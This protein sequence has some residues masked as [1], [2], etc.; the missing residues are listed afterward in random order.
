[1]PGLLLL[2]TNLNHAARAQDLFVATLAEWDID[3]AVAA[4]PYQIPDHPNWAG[5]EDGLVAIT[6]RNKPDS[7]PCKIVARG[8]GIVAVQR[9]KLL[10]VGCYISPNRSRPVFETYLGALGETL[11][12]HPVQQTLVLGD[13]NA[14]ST[15]WG[16]PRTDVRGTLLGEWLT[17]RGL[18]ILNSGSTNTCVRERGGSIIDLSLATR[19]VANA[20]S[21]WR[22]EAGTETLS[23]H[24]YIRIDVSVPNQTPLR[25]RADDTPRWSIRKMDEDALKAAAVA[26]TWATSDERRRV[27]DGAD[28]FRE[29]MT[30]VCD[31]GMPRVGSVPARRAVYWWTD[32]IASLRREAAKTR[33]RYTRAREK[34]GRGAVQA[35]VV[36]QLYTEYR[37]KC[38]ALQRNIA[39]AK[40]GAWKELL[41]SVEDDPWGRPYR[42][43][44]NKLRPWTPPTTEALDPEFLR[45]VL[46][47]LFPRADE[48]PRPP[49][50]PPDPSDWSR[51]KGVS[52]E[53]LSRAMRRLGAKNTA[54]GPDGI[55]GKALV[56]VQGVLEQP[57]RQLFDDCLREGSFPQSWKEARLV[58]LRKEGKPA[59][60][61]SAYR[62]ICLLDETG[63]LFER[64][65]AARLVAHLSR[66]GPDVSPRQFGFRGGRSTIDAIA[67]VRALSDEVVSQ[68]GKALAV[69]LDISNAFNSLPW[70]RIARALEY[71]RVPAYL[72]RVLGAYLNDRWVVY[73]DA[74][75][76]TRRR[77]VDRGVPQGSVLGPLLWNLGYDAVLRAPLPM[78]VSVTCYADDTLILARG[79]DTESTRRAAE[80][81]MQ[82]VV[83]S[84]E[85]MGL[86]VALDKT[87][88]LWFR[89]PRSR[90]PPETLL[91]AGRAAVRVGPTLNYLGLTLDGTWSFGQH[92]N[93]LA[94]RLDKT[95]A[96]LSRLLPNLGGP[97]EGVRR[98]Y[99]N[100]LQSI[101][102][103]GAPIWA[104]DLAA[105]RRSRELLR[106]SWR[107]IA[108]RII[109]GYKTVSH[110]AAG[111]LARLP[112][113]ELLAEAHA[114]V[115]R[116]RV[117]LRREQ[118]SLDPTAVELARLRA[119]EAVWESWEARLRELPRLADHW[120]VGAILPVMKD[121][122]DRCYGGSSYRVTQVLTGHGCFGSYLRRIGK[123]AT[124]R[125]YH[126]PDGQGEHR[127][128]SARHT[129]L[130]CA[131]WSEERGALRG[132][133][134]M[135]EGDLSLP[136]IVAAMVRDEGSWKA[137]ASFC[138]TVIS[139]KEAA[140]REREA[141]A[142]ATL[143]RDSQA[144]GAAR[145]RPVR[146][147][148]DRAADDGRPGAT[149]PRRG[150]GSQALHQ[151]N[152]PFSIEQE[153]ASL[154]SR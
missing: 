108:V 124:A 123:E 48:A 16:C 6:W 120:T 95:A 20:V 140:E 115:Y 24:R 82:C 8:K 125:C 73:T 12:R 152:P 103:Y 129:L 88:A 106:G 137:M 131:A 2:Q 77:Q 143:R 64:I 80:E 23:D 110:E 34:E 17:A 109:R 43:V 10:T 133:L 25:R 85:E 19:V 117:A 11:D 98:L 42:M 141:A 66:T 36:T 32:E 92:F 97:R 22:V 126:C 68:G 45:D 107:R 91:R 62:P 94:P 4:E 89:A 15:D 35:A 14:K 144:T 136:A 72:R 27:E 127:E 116:D 60:S 99:A 58:L 3:L 146:P 7:P 153:V 100:V 130:E 149:P 50:R 102:L 49:P 47:A 101:A 29:L 142:A 1:M 54:P 96:A 132:A 128:D 53:E 70:D 93:R 51:D 112:P 39:R 147:R 84:I 5:D 63:K 26:L 74:E 135:E 61:P 119:R 46:H 138:E 113:P 56:K 55:P 44:L 65:L 87:E 41:Q 139:Q 79:E 145:L 69:S 31:A 114:R 154:L 134:D 90:R 33:R 118:G 13:F 86:R 37:Q 104:P 151:S 59:D 78:G 81:G 52:A 105:S 40:A 57:L 75:G 121:W 148:L 38:S 9:G 67:S 83:A 28:R 21:R 111:L 76:G 150:G 30:R 18:L 71:H 122:R